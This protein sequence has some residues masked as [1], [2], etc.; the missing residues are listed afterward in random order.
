[1]EILGIIIGVLQGLFEWLPV[2]SEGQLIIALSYLTAINPSITIS[3]ALFAHIGTTL[4]VL[5]YYREDFARMIVSSIERLKNIGNFSMDEKNISDGDKLTNI[6][7][8]TTLATIPT[9]L[10]SLVIFEEVFNTLDTFI[11]YLG[12]GEII[13]LLVGFFLIITGLILKFRPSNMETFNVSDLFEQL[14]WKQAVILGLLQGFAAI[15]GISRSGITITYLL[16]GPKLSSRQALRGSFLISAPVTFGA[17][18]LEVVRGK[19][20]FTSEGIATGDELLLS[21]LGVFL[22]I[23]S[24][25][26]IGGITLIA[27]LELAKKIDFSKFLIILGFI[28]IIAI[29]IGIIL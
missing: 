2:S 12:A 11:P 6:I 18:F 14:T 28:A 25:F 21:Y 5:V 10:L 3:L 9:G 29:I 1:M 20:I 16:L 24:A 7:L 17:G 13:T 15:P 19:I 4:V 22:M 23:I 8:L 26:I 27:F